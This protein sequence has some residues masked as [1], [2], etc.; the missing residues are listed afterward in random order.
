[1]N[2]LTCV[3]LSVHFERTFSRESLSAHVAHERL[4]ITVNHQ[5]HVQMLTDA[6]LLRTFSAAK[7]PDTGVATLVRPQRPG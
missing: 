2:Q 7:L 3:G 6:E 5:V 4:L 1:M